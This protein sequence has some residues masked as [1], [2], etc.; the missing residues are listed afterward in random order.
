MAPMGCKSI[1]FSAL[2][3]PAATRRVRGRHRHPSAAPIALLSASLAA[4]SPAEGPPAGADT[5]DTLASGTIVVRN[6]ATGLWDAADTWRLTE[7]M[8]IGAVDGDGPDA[9]G[10]INGLDVDRRG[11]LYVL[12]RQAQ[13]VRVFEPD[14]RYLRTMGRK[15]G[16]PGELAGANG[17]A[18]DGEGRVWINDPANRRYTVYDTAGAFVT[19]YR[20]EGRGF[21]YGWGG[22]VTLDGDLW[23]HW[24]V[25]DGALQRTALFRFDSSDAYR[26]TLRL[27]VFEP[28]S[29]TLERGSST[30]RMR[31]LFPVPF[32]A[33]E[34]WRLDPR[35]FVWWNRSDEYRILQLALT[36]D[37]V[38]IVERQYDRLPVTA[39]DRNRALGRLREAFSGAN[40]PLDESRVPDF[41]PAL[42]GFVVD[43]RGYLWTVPLGAVDFDVF[44][45]EGRYLGVVTSSMRSW[46]L[47][48]LPI[49][50]GTAMYYV[51]TDDL[52]VPHVVRA[53]IEGRDE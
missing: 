44:D 35:G 19:S 18:L 7:A 34:Q 30:D 24:S 16:G 6:A 26:D 20:R 2:E 25:L 50:R 41:K 10:Q 28:P 11:R 36:G 42:L 9:F 37:T 51:V 32:A 22:G 23:D 21:G 15:G 33:Q 8:R 27:P 17:L 45:P 31:M 38:R 14:G 53:R 39:D 29:Y 1:C 48:P 49:V 4:C 3:T 12:E 13:E 40:A 43:D 52:D 47:A 5:V 46:H